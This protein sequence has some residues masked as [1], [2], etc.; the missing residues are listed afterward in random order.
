MR[1]PERRYPPT[2]RKRR[3][4]RG[5]GQVAKS[6]ELNSVIILFAIIFMFYFTGVSIFDRLARIVQHSFG[7]IA[8]KEVSLPN[9]T[10]NLLTLLWEGGKI[11]LPIMILAVCIAVLSNVAQFGLIFSG[12]PLIPSLDRINP[13]KGFQQRIFSK[14]ALFE[15]AKSILKVVIIGYVAYI[16]IKGTFYRSPDMF[17][18][19]D[20][21]IFVYIAYIAKIVFQLFLRACLVLLILAFLDYFYQRWEHEQNLLMTLR[22][23]RE[24]LRSEEGDPL[25]RQRIRNLQRA[26]A[27]QRMMARVEEADIVITNPTSLAVALKYDADTMNAPTV[28]AKGERLVAQKIREVAEENKIP[29]VENPT[30]A[31]A[32]YRSVEIDDEIPEHLYEAVVEVLA[33]VY[34]LSGN[35]AA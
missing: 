20:M 16:T 34:R 10:E 7:L 4:A 14:R 35:Q 25:I 8:E 3:E 1:D 23:I 30:L 19:M 11:I 29:I 32:L 28:I 24:D 27:R 5:R 12:Q 15:L 31:Q 33:Y 2:R 21:G 6:V 9:V 22:E 26:A 17:A 18:T 13:I